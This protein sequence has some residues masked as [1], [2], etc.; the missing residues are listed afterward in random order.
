MKIKETIM[1]TKSCLNEELQEFLKG[2][3]SI[4]PDEHDTS[5]IKKLS[6]K[7]K[8]VVSTSLSKQ[9]GVSKKHVHVKTIKNRFASLEA[10]N[11]VVEM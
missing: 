2:T 4:E 11:V 8:K 1:T 6:F 3:T 5:E 7:P 9:R 10:D